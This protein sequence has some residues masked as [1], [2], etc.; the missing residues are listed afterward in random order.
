ME[1]DGGH[2]SWMDYRSPYIS[3]SLYISRTTLIYRTSLMDARSTTTQTSPRALNHVFQRPHHLPTTTTMLHSNNVVY[4]SQPCPPTT[5]A[6][7]IAHSTWTTLQRPST[8]PLWIAY[9]ERHKSKR[10]RRLPRDGT[11]ASLTSR[12]F[13][14]LTSLA[15]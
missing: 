13:H 1:S 5:T 9:R 2:R 8:F 10:L 14:L 12:F 3:S 4:Q 6:S 15:R 11:T 7:P